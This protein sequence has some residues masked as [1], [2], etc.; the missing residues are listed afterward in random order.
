VVLHLD[1]ANALPTELFEAITEC[2]AFVNWRRLE[3]GEPAILM[4][5]C[6]RTQAT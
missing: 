6:W 3:V 1:N 2:C 5:S 4:L